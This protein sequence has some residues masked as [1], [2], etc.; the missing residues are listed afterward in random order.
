MTVSLCLFLCFQLT[1]QLNLGDTKATELAGMKIG[2]SDKAVRDW[3]PQFF[4]NDGEI[5]E[6]KHLLCSKFEQVY[7]PQPRPAC[8]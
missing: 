2:R 7:L 4:E 3:R 1:K 6:S 5:P 8:L